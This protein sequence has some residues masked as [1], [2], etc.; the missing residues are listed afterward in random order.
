VAGELPFAFLAGLLSVVTPCVLPLV[1]VYLSTLS[2]VEPSR[3]GRPDSVRRVLTRSLPFFL[4]FA[5]VF[6]TLG[7][8]AAA[9]VE[10]VDKREQT[11]IAG[12]VL[13]VFGLAFAGLLPFPERIVGGTLLGRAREQGSGALLGGAFALCAA[14]CIG[15]VLGSVLIVAGEGGSVGDAA[16]VLAAYSAGIA[17]AF[18]AAG[19]A[20]TRTM[21]AFRWLRDRW[22]VV[23]AVSGGILIAV[24]LLL[25]FDRDGWLQIA[26][27]RALRLIGLGV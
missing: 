11:R 6:V 9:I 20:F 18:A 19:I 17:A 24:G 7:A 10:V 27:N 22:T 26:F 23:Q 1:P 16:I 13:V 4:G 2:G 8:F 5:A 14:P 21:G 15:P 25:F 3:L 12:F